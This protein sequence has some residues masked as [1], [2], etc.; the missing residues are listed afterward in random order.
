MRVSIICSIIT[1][2]FFV[3]NTADAQNSIEISPLTGIKVF[4]PGNISLNGKS[5]GVE[6]VYN[7]S[8]QENPA[9]W[10]K[11]LRVRDIGIVAGYRNMRQ[12]YISDSVASKGFLK[13]VYTISGR[14]NINLLNINKTELLF[15]SSIG[16]TYTSTSFFTDKNPLVGSRINFSP[17]AGVKIRTLLSG[18]TSLI[19]G[20]DIFHYSN[21]G[22]RVPN[23]GVN[24]LQLSLGLVTGLKQISRNLKESKP[25]SLHGFFE[26]G[27]DIGYRGAFKSYAG[28]WKSGLYAGYNY[29]INHILSLKFGTDAVYYYTP[30]TGTI[31]TF[32]YFATSY[33]RW[34]IGLD[35]GTDIWLGKLGVTGSYGHYLKYHSYYPLKWY[36]T[37]GLKHY[38]NSWLGVQ[39]KMYFHKSQADYVGLGP[40]F[41][42][43]AKKF[44]Y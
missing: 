44:K 35:L 15:I 8:Q 41:R 40:L 43:G 14:L 3:S 30:F 26:I 29:K 1:L 22:L 32:Q 18:S 11:K 9:E 42:F 4:S 25:D 7:I 31:E 27:A 2:L 39:G 17:Q 24:S 38:L 12:V 33:D 21:V 23:N 20:A 19:G 36:W 37:A 10:I 34:R 16:V 5:Y 13:D 28:N 6:A